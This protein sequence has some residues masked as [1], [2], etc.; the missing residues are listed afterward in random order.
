MAPGRALPRARSR[1]GPPA[2][3]GPLVSMLSFSSAPPRVTRSPFAAALPRED[4]G[5]LARLPPRPHPCSGLGSFPR[6]ATR[7]MEKRNRG[8]KWRLGSAYLEFPARLSFLTFPRSPL[9]RLIPSRSLALRCLLTVSPSRGAPIVL[10]PPVSA[11]TFLHIVPFSFPC[12]SRGHP[13]KHRLARR[14]T[15]IRLLIFTLSDSSASLPP[16]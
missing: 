13:P 5:V 7:P 6:G 1:S 3:P 8:G 11:H 9:A 16:S 15:V 4:L 12:G 14:L 10:I 2:T